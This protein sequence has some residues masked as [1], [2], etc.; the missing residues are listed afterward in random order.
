M[1]RGGLAEDWQHV[2]EGSLSRLI[3]V[4]D[5][6]NRV[7]SFGKDL[8]W[9]LK[10]IL[11]A[12]SGNE[13]VLDA[14]CGPGVMTEVWARIHPNSKPVLLDALA[15]MLGAAKLRVS[16]KGLGF[17]RGVFEALPFKDEC[18]DGVMMGFSF[19]DARDMRAALAE[20][21]RVTKRGG[22]LLIVD[23]AKPDN[24]LLRWIIGVYWR[25]LVPLAA[26]L[27]ARRYWRNY[28]VLYTTY[29]RLP[30]NSDLKALVAEYY[31]EVTAKTDMGGGQIIL[32]AKNPKR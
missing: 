1:N 27:V 31:E 21:S 30:K 28:L 9:R 20:L 17:V 12:F 19:R 6:M 24:P 22:K 4:Y 16:G 14:G 29:R 23:I 3:P 13:R 25:L 8:E 5:K 26:F 10:G 15:E 11:E 2:V 7:M 32:I 18:F